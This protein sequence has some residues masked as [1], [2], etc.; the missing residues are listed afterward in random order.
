[1]PKPYEPSECERSGAPRAFEYELKMLRFAIEEHSRVQGQTDALL[2]CALLHTRNLLEF[3]YQKQPPENDNICAGHF[4]GEFAKNKTGN[5]WKSCRLPYLKSQK[6]AINKSLSHLTYERIG[7]EYKWDLAKIKHEVE[8]A[9]SEFF[10]L[11]PEEDRA[12]WLPPE[13]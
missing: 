10:N 3:F 13:A 11:L 8:T 7:A 9:Y 6:V 4:V 1:M 2:E 5:W 12:K